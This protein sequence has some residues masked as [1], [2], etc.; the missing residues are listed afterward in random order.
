V[1]GVDDFALRRDHHYGTILI[2]V[3]SHRPVD[4]LTDRTAATLTAWLQAHPGVEI[5]WRD[6]AGAYAEGAREG[7]SNA[8]QV[9]DRWHIR[10]N[11]AEAVE[12]TVA[13]HQ[14]C[15]PAALTADANPDQSDQSDQSHDNRPP[16]PAMA[17]QPNDR[18]DRVASRTRE[19]YDAIHAL[20]A[21]GVGIKEICRQLDWHAAPCAA[22]PAPTPSKNCW[23]TTELADAPAC[24]RN[25]DP[26]CANA[27]T[28]D[29][30]THT[31]SSPRSAHVA[32]GAVRRSCASTCTNS[33]RQVIFPSHRANR[34]RS[35][36]SLDGS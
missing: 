32:T 33:V 17:S 28:T 26:T 18:T 27:S 15:L 16:Q 24:W 21:E 5:V 23:P 31:T 1:L 12:R 29:A 25:S 22:S 19:R 4:V 10:H 2:D 30:P 3:E 7:A 8:V 34:H 20:L 6:R 35:A 36:A 14:D 11:L 9:A 13:R